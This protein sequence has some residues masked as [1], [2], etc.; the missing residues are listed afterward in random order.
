MSASANASIA[1]SSRLNRVGRRVDG[2]SSTPAAACNVA[3]SFAKK[4]PAQQSHRD[5]GA[6]HNRGACIGGNYVETGQQLLVY[7]KH[8]N[9]M[10]LTMS[11]KPICS[12]LLVPPGCE[13]APAGLVAR[14]HARKLLMATFMRLRPRWYAVGGDRQ[15]GPVSYEGASETVPSIGTRPCV[16][17]MPRMP[18]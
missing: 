5:P 7:S 9:P 11:L 8:Q 15:G 2:F 16:G 6:L 4:P 14:R 3:M 12:A 1:T 10:Q 18:Q 17:R 13:E